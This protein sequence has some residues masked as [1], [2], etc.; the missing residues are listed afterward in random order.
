MRLPADPSPR[1]IF[2]LAGLHLNFCATCQSVLDFCGFAFE[3]DWIFA[4]IT[5]CIPPLLYRLL[6]T[7]RLRDNSN[8]NPQTKPMRAG[9]LKKKFLEK[10]R[11]RSWTHIIIILL[12]LLRTMLGRYCSYFLLLFVVFTSVSACIATLYLPYDARG[13]KIRTL[14]TD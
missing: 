6:H 9:Y 10:M 3:S 5:F 2:S 4:V 12:I 14:R 13:G 7:G 8:A 1:Y 11:S